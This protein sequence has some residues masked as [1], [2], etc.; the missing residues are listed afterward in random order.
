[1]TDGPR[2]IRCK[3]LGVSE[4]LVIG[5]V[6]RVHDRTRQVFHWHIDEADLET[7]R[8]RF[9]VAVELA[10]QQVLGIKEQ[11]EKRFGKDH[12]YIFDAHLLL[13]E[14]EKLIGDIERHLTKYQTNAEWAVKV[15]G[16]GLLHLYSEMKDDYLRERGSD[17]EDVMRRLLVALG[18]AHPVNRRLSEDAVIVSQDL[19]PSAVA[20]LDLDH[21]RAFATDSGGW[22]SHT[23]ILARGV[24]I[25]AVVGLRDFY[26]RA[27]TG[28]KIIV[29]STR[30]EVILHPSVATLAHY[31]TR[32]DKEAIQRGTVAVLETGPARTLDGVAVTLRANVE[33]PSEFDG[34]ERYGA[35]GIGLY[36]SEFLLARRG[37]MVSEDEQRVAYEAIAKVAGEHGAVI[38]LFDLGGDSLRE[39]FQEPEKNPALGL[40][41]IRF[42]LCNEEVM[43]AQ[44]RAILL[45]S[46][47]GHL[48][49][50]LPMVADVSDVRRA[51][52][53]ILEEATALRN[54]GRP[55]GE[56]SIGAMIEVPSAVFMADKIARIVD[57][58]E[59][60][61]NDLV[62]YTLAVDRGNDEV[63]DWFRTLHPA[64]LHS[65]DQSLKAARKAGIPAI[66]CGEMASTPAYVVLLL[67]LG[68]TDLS[69]TPSSIPRVRR[70][71][72]GVE[73]QAARQIVEECLDCDTADEVED[74]VRERLTALWPDLFPPESLPR[75]RSTE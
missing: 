37:A 29:D 47:T 9:R 21:A 65:I 20:E 27:R 17:I 75:R 16:D 42:V 24:G 43:R 39:E 10:I 6:L 61:T 12:A 67:G 19:L 32:S 1:M 3:G 73:A 22:T 25:P 15:V 36:R 50:V 74:L 8:R 46:T 64:V 7:E 33:V 72:A 48:K 52:A 45:A 31:Q 49:I 13:L 51:Q 59:L 53:I 4:G 2:E 34:V 58:F 30:H 11:A 5:Q 44:V 26:R 18:G 68:A 38:R 57:F 60:G 35:A 28:D 54:A 56:L 63:A 23:A 71:I 66:V 70:A 69:M 14:D 41:A 40:R 62:Q 55:L